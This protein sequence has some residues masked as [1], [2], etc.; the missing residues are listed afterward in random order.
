MKSTGIT[1]GAVLL[2]LRLLWVAANLPLP[3]AFTVIALRDLVVQY[4]GVLAIGAMSIAMVL[5]VRSPRVD[6]TAGRVRQI[7]PPA[8]VAGHRGFGGGAGTLGCGERAEMGDSAG[9][10]GG[11]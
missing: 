3:D 4:S 2:G 10:D 8:Q 6:R 11:T 5:A 9:S 7:L 1:H